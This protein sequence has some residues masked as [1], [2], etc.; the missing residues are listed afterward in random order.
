[1]DIDGARTREVKQPT[2]ER[3]PIHNPPGVSGESQKCDLNRIF[4]IGPISEH[5]LADAPQEFAM[6]ADQCAEGPFVMVLYELF[7]QVDVG[8]IV[9]FPGRGKKSEFAE[10]SCTHETPSNERCI[11]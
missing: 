9:L 7:Q 1:M 11:A 10:H 2:R 8:A 6:T 5:T 4:R 3:F